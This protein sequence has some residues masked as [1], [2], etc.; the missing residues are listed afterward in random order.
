MLWFDFPPNLFRDESSIF[1]LLPSAFVL[2]P[3]HPLGPP[4]YHLTQKSIRLYATVRVCVW[5]CV[6]VLFQRFCVCGFACV[7]YVSWDVCTQCAPCFG[8][9]VH[10][11][12]LEIWDGDWRLVVD[13][14]LCCCFPWNVL[15]ERE[16]T[17]WF[18]L[19]GGCWISALDFWF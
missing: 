7:W 19:Y 2:S 17:T 15:W 18:W 4:L 14:R 13:W 9:S 8:S 1:T 3:V 16:V 10:V 11:R 5:M 6:Y 12:D